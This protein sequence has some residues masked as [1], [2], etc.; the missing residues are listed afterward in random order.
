MTQ[1]GRVLIIDDHEAMR[2]VVVDTLAGRGFAAE[3]LAPDADRLLARLA[4]DDIDVVLTDLRMPGLD[5]LEVV[6]RC[7]TTRPDVPVVLMTAFGSLDAA[8]DAM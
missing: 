7:S 2:D 1:P 3:A 6:R 4:A 8:V 5:G